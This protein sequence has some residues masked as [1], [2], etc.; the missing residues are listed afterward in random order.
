MT[1]YRISLKADV[2]LTIEAPN[3]D[4]L[5][6]R[7]RRAVQEFGLNAG[8]EIG[9]PDKFEARVIVDAGEIDTFEVLSAKPL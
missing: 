3:P 5:H 6:G 8:R 9:L 2:E 4:T 1:I 7:V